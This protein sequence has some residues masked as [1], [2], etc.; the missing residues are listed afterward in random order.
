MARM[1]Y[2]P[3][4]VRY[5]FK[6]MPGVWKSRHLL[7]F[8]WL[9]FMQ[10]VVPGRKSLKEISRY[11]PFHIPEWRLRRLL[12]ATYWTLEIVITW[13]ALETVK[14]FPPPKDGIIYL[15]GDSSHKDKRGRENPAVQKGR[16][17]KNKPRFFGIRFVIIAVCRDVYRI[18]CSFRIILPKDHDEYK[19]E[20]ALFR[21]TVRNFVPP[22]RAETVIVI[23]DSAYCSKE[24]IKMVKKKNRT[25]NSCNW[26]YVFAIARTWKTI[27]N[28]S[29]K[30][31]AT[32]LPG[33]LYRRTWIPS[34]TGR[35]RKVFWIFG[36]RICLRH[37]GDVTI[38]LTKKGR[39]TGP[40]N[41]KMIVTNLPEA[42]ARQ[43]ISVYQRR[44]PA[45]IIFKEL[46][47]AL[48][49]GQ[50]QVT[51]DVKR[52]EKSLGIAVVSYLF[53]LRAGKQDIRPG[54]PWSI[55][56][57]QNNFRTEVISDQIEH[58]TELI[59]KKLKKAA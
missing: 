45:E 29:I 46:K 7:I 8:Y 30:N 51:K 41:T 47:S 25:D 59:I 28:K 12:K 36:K 34:L 1:S 32:Y 57:L 52:V 37:A 13:F 21:E 33:N 27:E 40:K 11:T 9:I 48:G 31:L 16:K 14:C 54:K 38:V 23:G 2:L 35:K 24:N 3:V 10:V 17:S 22:C 44:W 50:H 19:K 49:P 20:N 58:K 5:I 39:N 42:T 15:V 4:F 26:F 43:V 53:L 56:Q 18:P 55:F 6:G